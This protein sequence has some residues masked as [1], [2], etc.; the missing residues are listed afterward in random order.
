MKTGTRSRSKSTTEALFERAAEI[1]ETQRE[2][3]EEWVLQNFSYGGAGAIN[4]PIYRHKKNAMKRFV[5]RRALQLAKDEA[6]E[7]PTKNSSRQ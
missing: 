6:K 5:F 2:E 3:L 1:A 7:C 4:G